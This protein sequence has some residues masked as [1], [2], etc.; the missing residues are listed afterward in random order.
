MPEKIRTAIES[1]LL[2]IGDYEIKTHILDDGTRIIEMDGLIGFLEYLANGGEVSEEDGM[3]IGKF[4]AL[5]PY[6][7][8][9]EKQDE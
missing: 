8:E 1:G 4:I 3:K 2:K 7:S 6:I 5:T 9:E